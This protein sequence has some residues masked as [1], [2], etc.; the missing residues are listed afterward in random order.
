MSNAFIIINEWVDAVGA[1]GSEVVG[2]VFFDSQE[3]A[4]LAL[5]EIAL[6]HNA[7]LPPGDTNFTL[8]DHKAHVQWEEYYIQELIKKEML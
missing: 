8:E 2:G 1:E 4:W 5:K 3:E 6:E 7:D